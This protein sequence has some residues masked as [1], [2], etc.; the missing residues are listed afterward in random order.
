MTTKTKTPSSVWIGR[1]LSGLFVLFMLGASALPKLFFPEPSGAY[2]IMDQL[3][4]PRKFLPLIGMIELLG[5]VVYIVPRT[6]VL[7]AVLLTGL[8]GG[9]IATHLRVESSVFGQTLFG[10]YL[11]LIM[12]AGLW[13]RDA[14]LR[15]LLPF[16]NP[17]QG[18]EIGRR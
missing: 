10:L 6:R 9:A 3:G 5:T 1:V 14:A 15:R 16:A 11:G 13:L 4:W 8:L 17:G 18:D 7:G 12:W 2:A